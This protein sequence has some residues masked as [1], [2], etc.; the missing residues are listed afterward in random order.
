MMMAVEI[1]PIWGL[2]WTKEWKP[3]K[4]VPWVLRQATH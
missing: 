4:T 2:F 3:L 1:K